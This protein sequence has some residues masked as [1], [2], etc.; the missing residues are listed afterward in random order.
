MKQGIHLNFGCFLTRFH[1]TYVPSVKAGFN[2]THLA[3]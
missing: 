3:G 2:L 1:I